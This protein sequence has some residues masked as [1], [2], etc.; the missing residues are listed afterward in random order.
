VRQLSW[1]ELQVVFIIIGGFGIHYGRS[2]HM[3]FCIAGSVEFVLRHLWL[4]ESQ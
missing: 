1:L 3:N 2:S 4:S